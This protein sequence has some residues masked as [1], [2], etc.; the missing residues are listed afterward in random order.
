MPM[1]PLS[2]CRRWWNGDRRRAEHGRKPRRGF[3]PAIHPLDSRQLLSTAGAGLDLALTGFETVEGDRVEISYEVRS[4]SKGRSAATDTGFEIGLFRSADERFDPEEDRPIGSA[5]APLASGSGT[6]AITAPE[7]LR[8]DP[9]RPFVIAVADPSGVIT[10]TSESNNSVSIR[11]RVIGVVTHGG[12]QSSSFPPGWAVA[13]TE[14]VR[15]QG[16]DAVFTYTWAGESRTPGAATKQGPRLANALR[17]A[18]RLFPEDEPVDLHLIGHSQGTVV[19]SQALVSL[20]R[21]TTAQLAAGSIRLTMLD[22]HAANNDAPGQHDVASGLDGRLANAIIR[23]FQ[24]RARDP[25]VFV[26]GN[27]DFAEV[28]YQHTPA[29]LGGANGGLYNIHGQAPVP[30]GA[31]HC[32]LTGPGLGHQSLEGVPGWFLLNVV[33]TLSDGSTGFVCP[34]AMTA[35]VASGTAGATPGGWLVADDESLRVTGTAQPEATVRLLVE[36]LEGPGFMVIGEAVADASG[37]WAIEAQAVPI[38]PS[39]LLVRGLVPAGEGPWT[40]LYPLMSLGRWIVQ[41][42]A[43]GESAPGALRNLETAETVER[44]S[45]HGPTGRPVSLSE[46]LE[47]RSSS[48]ETQLFEPDSARSDRIVEVLRK[49]LE[50]QQSRR[51]T[52]P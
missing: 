2:W 12:I 15:A 22:P 39:R 25:I 7:G 16:Y 41:P 51:A 27:V 49:R 44:Q 23:D 34:S 47:R 38:G 21:L 31:V 6:V 43:E 36:P 1:N 30:G 48:R 40:T 37:A 3:R 5:T 35:R 28:Y 14:A 45:I 26:P 11:K 19:N 4:A 20:E 46:P 10:E 8:P 13:T 32:D 52:N 29:S 42:G 17:H 24:R 9:S 18:S 33:P 50:W